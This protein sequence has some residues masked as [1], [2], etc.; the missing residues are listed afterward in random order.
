MHFVRD[1]LR[2]LGDRIGGQTGFLL[3][4]SLAYMAVMLSLC[5]GVGLYGLSPYHRLQAEA[6]L[7]GHLYLGNSIDQLG[8][9]LAW[10]DGHVQ[11]VWGLGVG[12][13]LLPFQAVWRLF[14]GQMF[15]DRIGLGV[16]FALLAFYTGCTGRRIA[17][18]GHLATGVGFVWLVLLC[19]PLW[20]LARASQLVFEETVLY[21]VLI[22]LGIL[23]SVARVAYF[24]S[25]ADYRFGCALAA[26][27]GMVRPT[28]AIYGLSAVLVC[29]WI[30]FS[31]RR[32]IKEIAWGNSGFVAGLALLA[33]T[34][35]GRFGSPME[36]GHRLTVSGDS[37][38]YLTRFGN[39]YAETGTLD[40]V[41]EMFGLLFL[42]S[43][44]R[45]A[46]AFSENIFPWQAPTT[47]WR[48]LYLTLFDPSYAL[49]CL[50]VAGGAVSWFIR[51]LIGKKKPIGLWHHPSNAIVAA[52]L[53]WAGI[54]IIGLGLFYLRAPVIASRYLLDF[55][56]AF[57]ALL[58]VTWFFISRIM[59]K[60]C[61]A[62]L[63]GWLLY[64]LA[65]ARVPLGSSVAPSRPEFMLPDAPGTPRASFEGGYSAAHLP[66]ESGIAFNGHGWEPDTGFAG[67]VVTLAVD[68]PQF[69]EL[70]VS[71]R[72]EFNG[73]LAR[74]DVY[75]A[76]MDGLALALR[77]VTNESDG[78]KVTFDVPP[79]LRKGQQLLFV[80]FSAGYDAED[81]DSERFLY[82]VR[83]R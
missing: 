36:F 15:P 80:C 46:G 24:D 62:L 33:L 23:V 48:R 61:L 74:K 27:S 59:P 76:S 8:P 56:P 69:I 10:H 44:V 77:G 68:N 16:A 1:R 37:M 73:V 81:R 18:N 21:G 22:S 60:V 67:D 25:R 52:Q 43:N 26:L 54:A 17:G 31:R 57:V 65:T 47:R 30:L 3:A 38:V 78:L 32:A 64:E 12:L 6:L 79:K 29:S 63:A 70:R 75:Q 83:W 41:K 39:P 2:G 7:H 5:Q 42:D 53:L 55:L 13:W 28:L 11:Q 49:L 72:R 71:E 35:W 40:A 9:G 19:P 45:D 66:S 4:L 50:G 51:R 82:S 58:M 20:T 34:N 14:G